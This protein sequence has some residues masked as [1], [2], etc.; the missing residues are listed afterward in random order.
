MTAPLLDVRDLH[1]EFRTKRGSVKAVDGLSYQV[2]PGEIVALVGESG[3][4][5]SVSSLAL[6][7]LLTKPAGRITKGEIL[8]EGVDLARLPEHEM[9]KRRG[10]DIAMIFQEPMT[11]L[12]PVLPIGL[13]LAEPLLQ[14]R[15]AT[16]AEARRR[17]AELLAMVGMTDP[18]RRL[19]QYPH[20]LSGG[21]RQRVMIAMGLA[22]D[23]KLLI[24]DE[25]TTALDVTIQAQ[26][27]ELLTSLSRQLN[28]A[29]ILITH[30][31]GVVARY[32]DRVNVMYAARQVEGG[33]AERI[34]ANP[35]HPYTR[36]LLA[37]VPRLD[38]PRNAA[39]ATIDGAP[40]NLANPPQGCRFGPRCA[41]RTETCETDPVL[42]EVE[43]D[44]LARC[45]HVDAMS[46]DQEPAPPASVRSGPQREPILTANGLSRHYAVKN[47]GVFSRRHGIVRAVES[48]SF[49]IMAGETLGLVGESGS[50]KSTIGR[51]LAGLEEPTAGHFS[52]AL[53]DQAD[54]TARRRA[55]QVI[56]QDPTTALNPRMLVGEIIAEP[57]RVHRLAIGKIAID[58]R[59]ASLLTSVGLRAD[60]VERY[61][62]ELSGGQRQRVGIARAL[63]LEPRFIVCDEAVSALDVSI[64][65]QIVNLLEALQRE[66]GL[67]Y[68]FIAHDLAVVRHIA[69]RVAVLYL[70]RL[71]ELGPRDAVFANPSHPYTRAL[72]DAVPVPDPV[73]ERARG[74]RTLKGE[75]PSPLKPPAGCVFHTRCPIAK[76]ACKQS[77]PPLRETAPGRFVACLEA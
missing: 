38:R 4:G 16:V 59:V 62:H 30:N 32:A 60:M 37:A 46:N 21:M 17:S 74:T 12:N 50:G 48:V 71:M 47:G 40:P 8:F 33:T 73:A 6:M 63:A 23:P 39:L 61:P 65:G 31:L 70:G 13:Q 24:A 49:D 27:L 72:L 1:V 75:I 18:E 35:R 22:C 51:L 67:T 5:K 55:V 77:I 14:H 34:F 15:G 26:I 9:R 54:A 44:H 20:Q 57:I 3:C 56:F 53:G 19:D 52:I 2:R 76:E 41:H 11:S 68:L 42:A 45:W 25:P 36:G 66:L 29:V 10:R 7:G 58:A 64:Q 28:L 43:P 69:D